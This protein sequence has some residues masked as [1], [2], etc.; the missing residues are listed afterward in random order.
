MR[1]ARRTLLAAA[2]AASSGCAT[3]VHGT[4]QTVTMVSDPPGARVTVLSTPEGKPPVVRS[5]PLPT[6]VQVDLLRH[7]AD[8]TLRFEMDGCPPVDV[9]LKRG[10]SGWTAGNLL[11]INPVSMQGMSNPGREYPQQVALIL[12]LTFGIDFASGGA[13]TL[14]KTVVA[15]L[16]GR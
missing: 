6:P 16:C 8:L 2:V 10:V 13:Y 3:I 1:V 14:P 9:P 15:R 11:Y 12:P 4:R 7:E 5:K